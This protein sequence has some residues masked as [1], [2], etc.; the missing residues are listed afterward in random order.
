[1]TEPQHRTAGD[2]PVD[3]HGRGGPGTPGQA[4]E[5][6]VATADAVQATLRE[7]QDTAAGLAQQ[8]AG[9]LAG[10]PFMAL[11]GGG[12]APVVSGRIWLDCTTE[13]IDA[14]FTVQRHSVERLLDA[15]YRTA[16]LVAESGL[17]LAAAGWRT[18]GATAGPEHDHGA[19]S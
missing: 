18:V 7:S 11:S 17:A 9:R 5:A 8:W 2:E 3:D 12:V 1:M 16:G 15:Q 14:L 4:V 10:I 13:M 19:A 6:V